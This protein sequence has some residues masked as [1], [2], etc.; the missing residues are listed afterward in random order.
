LNAL[1]GAR[2]VAIEAAPDQSPVA[3]VDHVRVAYESDRGTFQALSDVFLDAACGECVSLIG[4]AGCGQTTQSR[5]G[6]IQDPAS[7]DEGDR[8]AGRN[9]KQ[10][11]GLSRTKDLDQAVVCC[12]AD[13]H[14]I[15]PKPEGA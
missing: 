2:P 5:P 3:S 7:A 10:A 4:P 11:R 12:A 9:P 13:R 6:G 14:P 8:Q 15:T 1:I